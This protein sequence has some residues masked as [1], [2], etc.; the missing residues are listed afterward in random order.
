MAESI[1]AQ[2][3]IGLF[4]YNDDLQKL[5][6]FKYPLDD[7][8]QKATDGSSP[9]ITANV[10]HTVMWVMELTEYNKSWNYYPRGR[11][12]FNRNFDCFELDMDACL[13]NQEIISKI[14]S[15]FNLSEGSVNI[16]PPNKTNN[17]TKTGRL[18]GHYT[19]HNCNPVEC[20]SN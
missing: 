7:E 20:N 5:I 10:S 15:E 8:I 6:S 9:Y 17:V 12:N 19:C 2:S 18:E 14:K 3:F 4:W 16:I 11:V 13:H 1:N